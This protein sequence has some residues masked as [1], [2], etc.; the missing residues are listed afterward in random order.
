MHVKAYHNSMVN[1]LAQQQAGMQEKPPNRT[2]DEASS[3]DDQ[4]ASQSVVAAI[5][6]PTKTL[7]FHEILALP[8]Y[9]AGKLRPAPPAAVPPKPAPEPREPARLL[10]DTQPNLNTPGDLDMAISLIVSGVVADPY[11]HY[12]W[13]ESDKI[14]RW[15]VEVLTSKLNYLLELDSATRQVK[16]KL[17]KGVKPIPKKVEEVVL[18]SRTGWRKNIRFR[19][20]KDWV[21]RLQR[22]HQQGDLLIYDYLVLITELHHRHTAHLGANVNAVQAGQSNAVV[23]PPHLAARIAPQPSHLAN[24]THSYAQPTPSMNQ[25]HAVQ[26]A[27]QQ[28]NP[29]SF[30]VHR[31][32]STSHVTG[33]FAVQQPNM[34][35]DKTNVPSQEHLQGHK[36]KGS[37]SLFEVHRPQKV[38]RDQAMQSTYEGAPQT[39]NNA[40][41][42]STLDPALSHDPWF[43][44]NHYDK[45]M[46]DPW[47]FAEDHR[48]FRNENSDSTAAFDPF[49]DFLND[50]EQAMP[51][52]NPFGD[53]LNNEEQD[54]AAAHTA[55]STQELHD[56]PTQPLSDTDAQDT[57]RLVDYLRSNR[58]MPENEFAQS[59][60]TSAPASA[61]SHPHALITNAWLNHEVES[62]LQ[63][64]PLFRLLA[65]P[66]E[67]DFS[68]LARC[69]RF[70]TS[71]EQ[72][73]LDWR[74][75]ESH[76][77]EILARSD[78]FG[79]KLL[80]RGE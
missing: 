66:T 52:F 44:G 40:F 65:Q 79:A 74:V 28:P 34:L 69:I 4:Q 41:P 71:A 24:S 19:Y 57:Q 29:R 37:E 39:T 23:V 33:G 61:P 31:D 10:R 16:A 59:N 78:W 18:W 9:E 75:C 55:H 76:V 67:H 46:V 62:L 1:V 73:G 15:F 80:E 13:T 64:P 49:G 21:T 56:E 8:G 53:F 5:P 38:A 32:E 58:S 3:S 48:I 47:A 6:A 42:S 22:V 12:L 20:Y 51:A 11:P 7:R 2:Q 35:Q 27:S 63:P 68:L 43:P 25:P 30:Q 14:I 70:A 26:Q 50:E 72:V 17:L 36:R 60:A 54:A 77:T 45:A